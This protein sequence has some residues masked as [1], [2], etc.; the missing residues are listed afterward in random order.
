MSPTLLSERLRQLTKAGVIERSGGKGKYTYRLTRAGRELQ[1]VVQLMGAW[2]HR[3]APSNLDSGDL[4]A[5]LLMWDMRRSVNPGV[6]PERRIVVQFEYPDAPKGHRDWW[7][8]SEDG[9]VALCL[10][11]P[12]GEIDVLIKSPLATMTAVW[13]CQASFRDVVG[14][15]DVEVFGDS[16]VTEKLQDWLQ[17]SG[18][19]KLG[20]LDPPEIN[21]HVAGR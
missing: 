4:D 7:L 12:G 16:A 20:T 2:G 10:N 11:D 13:T 21:W 6:F 8:I 3:W 17:A 1:P 9:E 15:R 5:G 19:S 14:K 18:L